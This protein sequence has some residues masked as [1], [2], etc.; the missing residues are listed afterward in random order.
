MNK[1]DECDI[2]KDLAIQYTENLVSS[3]SKAIIEKHLQ[4]C[5]E[6]RNYYNNIKSNIFDDIQNEKNNEKTEVDFMKKLNRYIKIIKSILAIIIIII[7]L[8]G[9]VFAMKYQIIT[10]IVNKSYKK[11]EELKQLNNYKLVEEETYINNAKEEPIE[12]LTRTYYYKDGKSKE[13]LGSSLFYYEDD[14]YYSINVFNDLK[15]ISYNRKN[16]FKQTKGR[17]F[18]RPFLEIINSKNIPISKIFYSLRTDKYD[19]TECYVLR[20]GNK[21]SY[22]DIWIDKK[23]YNILRTVEVSYRNYIREINWY[24]YED[25]V[26]NED[27]ESSI[28]ETDLYKDYIKNYNQKE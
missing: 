18:E 24:L 2:V 3:K 9:L 10:F 16:Y 26:T 4:T 22:F 1:N 7:I 17:V 20:K 15:Q 25:E 11:M 28:L 13:E 8:I 14:S 12:I 21:K 27:V 6:C 19:E 23:N 5:D